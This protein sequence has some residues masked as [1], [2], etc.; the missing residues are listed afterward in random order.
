MKVKFVVIDMIRLCTWYIAENSFTVYY[1]HTGYS[2]KYRN[3]TVFGTYSNKV[4]CYIK[5]Y[6]LI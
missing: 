2:S 4:R 3:L 5:N 6:K 1:K